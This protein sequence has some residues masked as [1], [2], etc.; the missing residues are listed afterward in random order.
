MVLAAG[1]GTNQYR[2]KPRR[3]PSTAVPAPL[4]ASPSQCC[5]ELYGTRCPAQVG[6][7]DWSHGKHPG[8]RSLDRCLGDPRLPPGLL[9]RH[10]A[11]GRYQ[12]RKLVAANLSCPPAQLQQLADDQDVSVRLQVARNP[13]CPLP[14]LCQLARDHWFIQ[15]EVACHPASSPRLLSWL[16][17][18][19]KHYQVLAGLAGNPRTP[20]P[21]QVQVVEQLAQAG[22]V[23][24]LAPLRRLSLLSSTPP[25]V[26]DVIYRRCSLLRHA[27]LRNPGCP[28]PLLGKEYDQADRLSRVLG[29]Y[30]ISGAYGIK[31]AVILN[32]G[33]PPE[34]LW[35]IV[36]TDRDISIRTAAANS[37][38]RRQAEQVQLR[39]SPASGYTLGSLLR[40]LPG[41]DANDLLAHNTCAPETLQ[42][43]AEH[44]LQGDQHHQL[45]R[46]IAAHPNCPPELLGRLLGHPDPSVARHALDNPRLPRH[47]LAMYQLAQEQ[48]APS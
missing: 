38:V 22:T 9:A 44:Y 34:L 21:A 19:A 17:C 32:P 5:G 43:L 46:I 27:V 29:P 20:V 48:Q 31:S 28:G 41:W 39:D 8:C 47:L 3:V 30:S 7:P 16:S 18:H 26:L 2:A 24:C 45:L 14:A 4:V 25:A 13:N 11:S 1:R 33:C 36:T 23:E 42:S 12:Q 37:A 6:P 10:A 40:D 15:Y 35:R